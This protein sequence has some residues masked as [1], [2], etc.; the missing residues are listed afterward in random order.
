[1]LL[2]DTY[3]LTVSRRPEVAE[4]V[5]KSRVHVTNALRLL[6]LPDAAQALVREGRLTAGHARAL[7]GAPDAARLAEQAAERGLTV[8]QVEALARS[9]RPAGERAPAKDADT[10]ALETDLAEVLGLPVQVRD[11]GGAG[12]LRIRYSTLEQLDDLCRRLTRG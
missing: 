12:E 3:T 11:H 7:V 4:I 1:M 2:R 8:R 6:Q 9:R 5:S 10:A